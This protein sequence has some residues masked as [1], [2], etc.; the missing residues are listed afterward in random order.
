L[1]T[2]R[3]IAVLLH[4]TDTYPKASGH[5]IWAM[6]DVWREQG[7]AVEV[8]K[9]TGKNLH[10]DLVIPHVDAT[11]L[12]TKY[13][14]YL[15]EYPC[16]VNRGVLDISKRRISGNL[17]TDADSWDGQVVVKT[18]LNCGGAPEVNFSGSKIFLATKHTRSI[19]RTLF[20]RKRRATS[21]DWAKVSCMKCED[22]PVFP[23]IKEVPP[24]IFSNPWLVVE[25]F[26]PERENGIYY[27]RIYQFFG[28]QGYCA[29]LGSPR[30][31][32]KQV[33]IV[34][35]EEVPIP[36]EVME[37]RRRLRMDYGKLDFVLHNGRVIVFDANRT[38]GRI[39]PEERR[40]ANARR[41]AD[42]LESFFR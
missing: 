24:A 16:V 18:N 4:E 37:V 41:L 7:H 23:S 38:P 27:L 26:L 25:R 35:R 31:I 32:V 8:V 2:P 21:D 1:A 6:R 15:Q 39:K 34:S 29:R 13:E 36:D 30:P 40:R 9:G 12:P 33:N 11:V 17:L 19:W 14:Q 42:G 10:A 3:K 5:F 22:Y 28:D 20:N